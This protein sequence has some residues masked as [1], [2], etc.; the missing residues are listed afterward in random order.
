MSKKLFKNSRVFENIFESIVVKSHV[1][2]VHDL[3]F[4]FGRLR[5]RF[6][7][8]RVL[9]ETFQEHVERLD[10][11]LREQFE[12]VQ[13][14]NCQCEIA[15]GKTRFSILKAQIEANR[16]DECWQNN[17]KSNYIHSGRLVLA[18]ILSPFQ[19]HVFA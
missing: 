6:W 17:K 7:A 4:Q 1:Q 15:L 14:S 10:T 19:N 2:I 8:V 5:N 11:V 9:D 13:Q 3:G 16:L 18:K 12:R